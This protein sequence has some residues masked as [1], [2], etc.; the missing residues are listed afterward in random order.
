MSLWHPM[1]KLSVAIVAAVALF[2]AAWP[3]QVV[4]AAAMLVTAAAL[5][6]LIFCAKRGNIGTIWRSIAWSVAGG[7]AGT[8]LSPSPPLHPPLEFLFCGI[9]CGWAVGCVC[10]RTVTL[11]ESRPLRAK[12]RSLLWLALGL[13]L[14]TQAFQAKL[15]LFAHEMGTPTIAVMALAT[16]VRTVSIVP[17]AVYLYV[18]KSFRGEVLRSGLLLCVILVLMLSIFATEV[19]FFAA[20]LHLRPLR[21]VRSAV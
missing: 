13:V 8:M 14:V 12:W 9:L 7:V 3:E 1:W 4:S 19:P 2:I 10:M 21:G 16:V 11:S 15:L 5:A 20:L 17:L 18:K 6:G